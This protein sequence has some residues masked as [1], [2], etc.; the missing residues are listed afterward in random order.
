MV[1]SDSDN[2]GWKIG[3]FDAA[4]GGEY[5]ESSVCQADGDATADTPACAGNECG[6]H[7]VSE[8]RGSEFRKLFL[9]GNQSN[10]HIVPRINIRP[11]RLLHGCGVDLLVQ[12]RHIPNPCDIFP[13]LILTRDLTQQKPILFA[14]RLKLTK[15]CFL[16]VS[17]LLLRRSIRLQFFNFLEDAFQQ[18]VDSLWI[19]TELD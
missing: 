8:C 12:F 2:I 6:L 4:A 19:T 5:F 18:D 7:A 11:C 13:D 14:A 3:R 1:A 15:E 17:D 10:S 9:F 16:F